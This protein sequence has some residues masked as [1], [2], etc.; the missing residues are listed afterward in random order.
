MGA[1][2]LV[3]DVLAHPVPVGWTLR[4]VVIERPREALSN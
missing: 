2:L 1:Y 3:R 4:N